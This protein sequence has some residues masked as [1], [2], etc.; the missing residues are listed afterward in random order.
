[1][2]DVNNNLNRLAEPLFNPETFKGSLDPCSAKYKLLV[3]I[4]AAPAGPVALS[5]SPGCRRRFERLR[6][7]LFESQLV[8]ESTC[9]RV[10][11]FESQF[12]FDETEETNNGF[13]VKGMYF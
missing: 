3:A 5:T 7:N 8:R 6:V 13:E 10:N 9:S 4:G 11:L 1:M 12:S 2:C